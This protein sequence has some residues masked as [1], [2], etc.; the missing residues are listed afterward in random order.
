MGMSSVA[1]DDVSLI[2]IV[3]ITAFL[4]ASKMR[5]HWYQ[6]ALHPLILSRQ[7][8]ASNVRGANESPVYRNI[9]APIG[10][11]LAIRPQRS[12][13]DVPGLLLDGLSPS[14]N[15]LRRRVFDATLSNADL[16]EQATQLAYGLAVLLPGQSRTLVVYG[17]LDSARSVVALLAGAGFKELPNIVTAVVPAGA[18]VNTLPVEG[19]VAVLNLT[20]SASPIKGDLVIACDTEHAAAM[21][22]GTVQW[23]D[24]LG[25]AVPAQVPRTQNVPATM[26]ELDAI[27]QRTFAWFYDARRATWLIATHTSMTSGVTAL[28]SEYT[29][30]SI[31]KVGDHIVAS[32]NPDSALFCAILMT[33][34]YTGSAV[35]YSTHMASAVRDFRPTIIYAD[36]NSAVEFAHSLEK[37]V[38]GSYASSLR[39]RHLHS[40]RNGIIPRDDFVD[41]LVGVEARRSTGAENVRHVVIIGA[42]C[43]ASQELLDSLRVHLAVPVIHAYIPAEPVAEG[44]PV[45]FTAPVSAS[46]VYD[47][48]AFAASNLGDRDLAAHVGPPSVSVELKVVEDSEAARAHA[49]VISHLRSDT[50]SGTQDCA[51]GE[52]VVRGYSVASASIETLTPR[53]NDFLG[54]TWIAT[55][56][57]G[58]VRTNGTVVVVQEK[59]KSKPG[60]ADLAPQ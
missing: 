47:F 34:L 13:P 53:S 31:P 18:S 16:V 11:D 50:T 8:D 26:S 4:V 20:E 5:R 59:G 15:A 21:G 55:G 35:T 49:G 1:V 45:A 9:N 39:M 22:S 38:P 7:A 30:E 10:L 27:G 29:A 60:V 44:T 28:L 52:I 57:I 12:A 43:A 36:G 25:A 41:R 24:I 14:D 37:A 56:D 54:S 40:L 6:P 51:I 42:G 32:I 23:N 58:Y 19:P 33:A 2:L 48:Q 17:S 3:L 46:N